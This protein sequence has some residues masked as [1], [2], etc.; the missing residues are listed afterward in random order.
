MKRT[1]DARVIPNHLTSTE[2]SSS[3][4]SIT[5]SSSVTN[6]QP[7]TMVN[8]P[9]NSKQTM[10]QPIA[11]AATPTVG[12]RATPA[13]NGERTTPRKVKK[14]SGERSLTTGIIFDQSN[15]LMSVDDDAEVANATS[16]LNRKCLVLFSLHSFVKRLKFLKVVLKSKLIF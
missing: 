9:F 2:Y 7:P 6:R 1:I 10:R 11:V 5:T 3:S 4:S 13:T 15:A 14:R 12:V 8:S 16:N